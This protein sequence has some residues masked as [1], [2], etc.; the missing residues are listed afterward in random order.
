MAFTGYTTTTTIII[1]TTI[2]LYTINLL[3]ALF[4]FNRLHRLFVQMCTSSLHFPLLFD[5]LTSIDHIFVRLMQF[6]LQS[7]VFAKSQ[8]IRLKKFE[9]GETKK[10]LSKKMGQTCNCTSFAPVNAIIDF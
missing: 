10:Q 1:I 5:P 3:P 8:E 6:K 9:K 7:S 4:Q 2:F